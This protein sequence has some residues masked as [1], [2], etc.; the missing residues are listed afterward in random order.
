MFA[1]VDGFDKKFS[2]VTTLSYTK[3]S[4]SSGQH[5]IFL[6]THSLS[7]R[8]NDA[9]VHLRTAPA[10]RPDGGVPL[11]QPPPPTLRPL[12]PRFQQSMRDL[13]AGD[14]A[15]EPLP[16]EPHRAQF[17]E[18]VD[19]PARAVREEQDPPALVLCQVPRRFDRAGVRRDPVV[20]HPELV[21]EDRRVARER[22]EERQ[23]GDDF[24]LW[25]RG[26]RRRRW[27]CCVGRFRL[28]HRPRLPCVWRSDCTSRLGR[29]FPISERELRTR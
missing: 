2:E 22:R 4:R 14:G 15:E 21:E 12:L 18:G 7:P 9:T 11:A 1:S 27:R 8:D 29:A 17:V 23:G 16:L 3:H 5:C 10:R 13:A 26:R 28:C 20:E 24:G 19:S 6:G 25:G